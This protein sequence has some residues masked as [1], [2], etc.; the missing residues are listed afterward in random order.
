MKP[1]KFYWILLAA[2]SFAVILGL[3]AFFAVLAQREATFFIAALPGI[4]TA[5]LMPPSY[6]CDP[7]TAPNAVMPAKAGTHPRFRAGAAR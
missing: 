5:V 2:S 1:N 7:I 6:I 4:G 3:L